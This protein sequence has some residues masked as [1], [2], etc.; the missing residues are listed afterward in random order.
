VSNHSLHSG[1]RVEISSDLVFHTVTVSTP[2]MSSHED[3]EF[4]TLDGLTI[5]GWLYP[6]SVRGPAIVITPGV[7]YFQIWLL[8]FGLWLS[9]RTLVI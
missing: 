2:K 3:V 6:A 1:F 5:R 8:F 4:K 9:S 7:S